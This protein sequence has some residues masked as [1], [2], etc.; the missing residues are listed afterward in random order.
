M[1]WCCWREEELTVW[2]AVHCKEAF[3]FGCPSWERRCWWMIVNYVVYV[4]REDEG[5]FWRHR[6]KTWWWK[7]KVKHYV[8]FLCVWGW[9]GCAQWC[10]PCDVLFL[11][12]ELQLLGVEI[13]EWKVS[14]GGR[15]WDRRRKAKKKKPEGGGGGWYRVRRPLCLSF[16]DVFSLLPFLLFFLFYPLVFLVFLVWV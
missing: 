11:D 3:P 15:D 7:E 1:R 4:G 10:S 13:K 2:S 6:R 16:F 14:D 12:E 8:F 5:F 9:G